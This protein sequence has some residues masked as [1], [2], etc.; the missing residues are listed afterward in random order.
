MSEGVNNCVT[1][2]DL[3]F[4][5]LLIFLHGKYDIVMIDV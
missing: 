1:Y 5:M 4:F 3:K 2:F